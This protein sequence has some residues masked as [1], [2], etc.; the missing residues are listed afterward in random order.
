MPGAVTQ[1][2]RERAE[3]VLALGL[4]WFCV[5]FTVTLLSREW[6]RP[7][8]NEAL[9]LDT[10]VEVTH[11]IVVNVEKASLEMPLDISAPERTA[12]QRAVSRALGYTR[13]MS[14]FGS[15]DIVTLCAMSVMQDL[16]SAAN[17]P[18]KRL[19]DLRADDDLPYF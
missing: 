12:F 10:P 11:R 15:D 16:L 3:T 2:A 14:I 9:A 6:E 17:A 1:E 8:H 7:S 19:R 13:R 5:D 18:R 4:E